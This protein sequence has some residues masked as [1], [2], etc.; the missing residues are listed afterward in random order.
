M[1]KYFLII[2]S[3]ANILFAGDVTYTKVRE[4][5][6]TKDGIN[7]ILE[8]DTKIIDIDLLKKINFFNRRKILAKTIYYTNGIFYQKGLKLYFKKAYFIDNILYM[9]HCKTQYNGYN[10]Q[11]KKATF[12]NS[13]HLLTFL[14]S[15]VIK[16]RARFVNRTIKFQF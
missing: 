7:Y 16:N 9:E 1:I 12:S 2:T 15:E 8:A 4:I 3:L 10:I 11:S 6:I 5:D 14:K 13:N